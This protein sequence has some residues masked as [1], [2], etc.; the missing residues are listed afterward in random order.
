[1]K[2]TIRD[3]NQLVERIRS[4]QPPQ[5]PK[6][7]EHYHDPALPGFYIRV[8]NT[9]VASWVLQWKRLGRQKKISIG[10]VLVLDRPQA[11]EGARKLLAKVTL[12]V[13]DPH[14]A[15]RDRMRAAKVTF[16]TVVPLF[17]E[18][19]KLRPNTQKSWER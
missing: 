9:G 17:I 14:E 10:D 2:C 1:M 4:G 19:K 13:L 5:L 7:E 3:I 11:I 18:K 16:A 8:L 15:R 6:P 12:D